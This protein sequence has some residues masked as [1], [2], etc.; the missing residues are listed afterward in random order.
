MENEAEATSLTMMRRTEREAYCVVKGRIIGTSSWSRKQYKRKKNLWQV[1]V[2]LFV[3]LRAVEL[4]RDLSLCS[5]F[6]ECQVM[7]STSQ[8][9]E[10]TTSR[11][12]SSHQSAP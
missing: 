7:R 5:N 6:Y 9:Q 11:P 8:S 12:P 3:V 10:A 1:Y 2:I 4:D